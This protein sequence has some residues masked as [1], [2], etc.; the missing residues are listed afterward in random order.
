MHHL[1]AQC[2]QPQAI[3]RASLEVETIPN[4]RVVVRASWEEEQETIRSHRVVAKALLGVIRSRNHPAVARA[5]QATHCL[6]V[7]R[8][9]TRWFQKDLGT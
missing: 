2:R 6:L 8:M 9:Q 1:E 7:P 3:A 5:L 4:H